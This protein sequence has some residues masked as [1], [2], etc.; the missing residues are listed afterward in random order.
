MRDWRSGN[1][2]GVER[3]T[4][5]EGHI[6]LITEPGSWDEKLLGTFDTLCFTTA[7]RYAL[8][9]PRAVTGSQSR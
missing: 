6:V 3:Y 1:A 4:W 2:R 9:F 8:S 7:L 5:L